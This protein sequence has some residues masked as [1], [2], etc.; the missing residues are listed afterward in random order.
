LLTGVASW[1]PYFTLTLHLLWAGGWSA[2]GPSSQETDLNK[3]REMELLDVTD[4][5]RNGMVRRSTMRFV[6]LFHFSF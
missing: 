6:L 3:D 5:A 1:Q 2:S 4:I